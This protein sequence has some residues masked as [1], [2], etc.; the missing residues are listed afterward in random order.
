MGNRYSGTQW[1][2]DSVRGF[3]RRDRGATAIQDVLNWSF[4]ASA[5]VN[6]LEGFTSSTGLALNGSA[7]LNG[8]RLRLTDGGPGEKVNACYSAPVNI[9]SFTQDFSLQPTNAQGD[10]MAF[11]IQNAGPAAVGSGGTSWDIRRLGA[12]LPSSLRLVQQ[13]RRGPGFHRLVHARCDADRTGVG[14]DQ[15]RSEPAQRRRLQRPHEL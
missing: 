1:R 4:A 9:Q 7:T 5:T 10:G 14:Y 12:A 8:A 11:V 3:H 6:Y 13:R 15:Q 2:Y